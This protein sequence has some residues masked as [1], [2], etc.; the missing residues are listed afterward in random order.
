[1]KNNDLA[2]NIGQAENVLRVRVNQVD[3][4]RKEV[5]MLQGEN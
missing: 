2:K 1:M 5:A 4:G 3:E